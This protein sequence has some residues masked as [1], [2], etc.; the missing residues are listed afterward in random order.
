M[1]DVRDLSR[2]FFRMRELL[3]GQTDLPP[4][5]KKEFERLGRFYGDQCC[6]YLGQHSARRTMRLGRDAQE[7][8][9]N[10]EAL[11]AQLAKHEKPMRGRGRPKG[12]SI[13][14]LEG[15]F[16]ASEFVA[17]RRPKAQIIDDYVRR[18]LL[19]PKKHTESHIKRIDRL[20]RQHSSDKK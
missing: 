10:V 9:T 17:G 15:L 8:V 3:D 12:Q 19:D 7:V 16:I 1:R 11:I 2:C 20:N 6:F 14:F 5:K 4:K 18:G 13:S